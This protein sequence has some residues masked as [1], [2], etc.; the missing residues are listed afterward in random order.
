MPRPKPTG[1]SEQVHAVLGPRPD[2][3][4]FDFKQRTRA[5][6][7]TNRMALYIYKQLIGHLLTNIYAKGIFALPTL[8]VLGQRRAFVL[9]SKK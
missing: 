5:H 2:P 9:S 8:G 1:A 6:T 3:C 7:A 4:K